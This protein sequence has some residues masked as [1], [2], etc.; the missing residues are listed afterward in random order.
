MTRLVWAGALPVDSSSASRPV[1]A[2]STNAIHRSS[3]GFLYLPSQLMDIASRN[4]PAKS[5]ARSTHPISQFNALLRQRQHAQRIVV[6][7]DF[8][9]R[10]RDA[11]RVKH[12]YEVAEHRAVALAAEARQQR[13]ARNVRRQD[14]LP[15]EP[16]VAGIAHEIGKLDVGRPLREA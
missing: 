8:D 4:D 12:R 15:L 11:A 13:L 9:R 16:L 10:G 5:A 1:T 3:S 6:Q 7:H 2:A 14:D